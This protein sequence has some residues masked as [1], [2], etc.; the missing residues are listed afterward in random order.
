[1]AGTDPDNLLPRSPM[2][3]GGAW[4]RFPGASSRKHCSPHRHLP[5]TELPRLLCIPPR[6]CASQCQAQ[7]VQSPLGRVQPLCSLQT[8]DPFGRCCKIPME[9]PAP[10]ALHCMMIHCVL[11]PTT[12]LL[13]ERSMPTNRLTPKLI[14]CPNMAAA[15]MLGLSACI[16]QVANERTHLK[17]EVVGAPT[18]QLQ[19]T[20]GPH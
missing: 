18:R 19:G 3:R 8:S 5:E 17:G 7:A 10:D 11:G 6:V 15:C 1:M 16:K 20:Q 14:F 12:Y 2:G 4:S 13:G 9:T